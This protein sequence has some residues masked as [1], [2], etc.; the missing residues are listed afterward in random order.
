VTATIDTAAPSPAPGLPS[1][2]PAPPVPVAMDVPG[3]VDG[4]RRR[5]VGSGTAGVDR[6]NRPVLALIG[7]LAAAAGVLALLLGGGGITWSESPA[8]LY[9]RLASD[10]VNSVDLAAAVTMAICLLAVLLGLW[11]AAAQ[12]RPVTDGARVG[13]IRLD[14]GPRGRTTAPGGAVAKAAAADLGRLRGVSSARV[15]LLAAT[16]IPQA[17]I[18]LEVAVDVERD[19]LAADVGAALG[20]LATALG[21]QTVDADLRIRFGKEG[22]GRASRVS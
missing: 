13:T 3:R 9:R 18:T 22:S 21:A 11:W 10:A 16:P 14:D 4:R 8:S 12:L 15:R 6:V 17:V 5:R 20:R 2:Q 7:A 1:R 19:A